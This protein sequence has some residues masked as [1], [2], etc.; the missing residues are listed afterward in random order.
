MMAF[1]RPIT[2]IPVVSQPAQPPYSVRAVLTSRASNFMLD[3]GAVF[4]D[5]ETTFGIRLAE[6]A[7][8]PAKDDQIYVDPVIWRNDQIDP[9]VYR[10]SDTA[11]D[12]QGG[13]VLTIRKIE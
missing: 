1:A 8:P 7:V 4:S 11:L 6:V 13:Q 9:G 10:I 2:I 3:Q 12:R 5:Q